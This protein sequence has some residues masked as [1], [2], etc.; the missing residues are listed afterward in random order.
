MATCIIP[1]GYPG[2]PSDYEGF[3]SLFLRAEELGIANVNGAD[4]SSIQLLDMFCLLLENPLF[5]Y[6]DEVAAIYGWDPNSIAA[7]SMGSF[8]YYA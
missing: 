2:V 3:V 8:L 6:L 5:C 4:E 7:Q 1:E